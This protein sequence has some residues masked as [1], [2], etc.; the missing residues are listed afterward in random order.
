MG[1][2]DKIDSLKG[3]LAS[4]YNISR[5]FLYLGIGYMGYN[6]FVNL[7][8]KNYKIAATEGL[9]AASGLLVHYLL[10][11]FGKS[12]EEIVNSLS[13][14]V[15]FMERHGKIHR[16]MGGTPAELMS[17]WAEERNG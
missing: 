4:P 10:K 5:S 14:L 8:Q 1:I 2:K 12:E 6:G 13:S 17:I 16:E 9:I 7:Y 3:Y 15:R 11:R